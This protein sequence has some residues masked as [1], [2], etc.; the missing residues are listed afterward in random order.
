MPIIVPPIPF[1][2]RR[3]RPRS[4][5]AAPPPPAAITV[6]SVVKGAGSDLAWTFSAD[7]TLSAGN[8]PELENDIDGT[9]MWQSPMSCAQ[10]AAAD[11]IIATYADPPGEATPWRIAAQPSGI[12]QAA[13][14][15]V[16]QS[17][18]VG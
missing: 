6:I 9:G 16:P 13:Q 2:R 17:G 4:P 7:V 11:S 5:G 18:V 3:G 1:I 15:T 10:G 14:V 12:V 8:V